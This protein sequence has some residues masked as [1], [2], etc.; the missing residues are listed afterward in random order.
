M[1]NRLSAEQTS[2][3]RSAVQTALR[4]LMPDTPTPDVVLSDV[5]EHELDTAF[6]ID[7]I[8]MRGGHRYYYPSGCYLGSRIRNFEYLEKYPDDVTI[9]WSLPTG[10]ATESHK[11][12]RNQLEGLDIRFFY[13]FWNEYRTKIIRCGVYVPDLSSFRDWE[14]DNKDGS[15]SFRVAKLYKQGKVIS[16]TGK[17]VSEGLPLGV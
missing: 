1:R 2:N 7:F 8:V 3:H 4:D 5:G 6:G 13:G 16:S 17:F 15:S 9:R 10:N 14:L 11:T 12:L